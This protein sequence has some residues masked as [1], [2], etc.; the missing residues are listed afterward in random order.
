MQK[1][2]IVM[3]LCVCFLFCGCGSVKE[4]VKGKAAYSHDEFGYVQMED[5]FLYKKYKPRE[6][7]ILE[8]YE[9]ESGAYLPLCSRV[10][11]THDTETCTAVRLGNNAETIGRLGDKWY[12]LLWEGWS[13]GFYSADL[14]GQ[15]EQK[16][17]S[18]DHTTGRVHIFFDNSCVYTA[19]EPVFDEETEQWS[20]DHWFA[21][22]YQFHFDTEEEE[23]LQPVVEDGSYEV[24]G[25]YE[26]QLLYYYTESKDEPFVL[27][28]LNLE[29]GDVTEPLG[30][31]EVHIG[32]RLSENYFIYRILK[33]NSFQIM[34][35]NL[36]TGEQKEIMA[37]K[38]MSQSFFWSQNLKLI[39]L[40]DQDGNYEMYQY[41]D[42]E[43]VKQI[44]KG[45]YDPYYTVI[46]ALDDRVILNVY[47]NKEIAE[48]VLAEIS[49][50]DFLSGKDN[51]T[52]LE[53]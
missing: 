52:L 37:G 33:G 51:W 46:E 15:N 43:E 1:K 9:Y 28:A 21:G 19:E 45:T 48:N 30:K 6:Y 7:T 47:M 49:R 42:T 2:L 40:F 44:R 13:Y 16:I 5:G 18:I 11:C 39:T 26:N 4:K 23:L 35:L 53:Y 31:T 24:L 10:N 12:Y 50:E 20:F 29:T 8:Y 36:E 14:D 41:L 22:L 27:R 38:N 34:E 32:D 3:L 17:G 25:K